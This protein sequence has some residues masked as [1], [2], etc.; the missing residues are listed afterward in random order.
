[1]FLL[2]ARKKKTPEMRGHATAF[3]GVLMFWIRVAGFGFALAHPFP[4]RSSTDQHAGTDPHQARG[5]A[6]GL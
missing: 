3:S 1:M 5:L 6:S 2:L 4:V